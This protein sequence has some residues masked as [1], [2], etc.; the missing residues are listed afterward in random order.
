M[1]SKEEVLSFLDLLDIDEEMIDTRL[2]SIMVRSTFENGHLANALQLLLYK[3][4]VN[5]QEKTECNNTEEFDFVAKLIKLLNEDIADNV[6]KITTTVLGLNS[7]N[8][9][10]F[11][12]HI[13]SQILSD[14]DIFYKDSKSSG[15]EKYKTLLYLKICDSVLDAT[16]KHGKTVSVLFVETPLEEILSSGDEPL[17]VHFITSTVPKLIEGLNGYDMLSR[18]WNHLEQMKGE[19]RNTALKVLSS[20]SDYYLPVS[21]DGKSPKYE[22]E[23]VFKQKFWEV[24]LYG[25]MSDD[26]T[27]RKISVYL[28]KRAIDYVA[29]L[30]INLN[31]KLLDQTLFSWI[32]QKQGLYRKQWDNFFILMDSLEE[33]Q[34]NIV[35]PSLQLF[36]TLTKIDHCWLNCAFNLGLRHDNGQVRLKCIDHRINTYIGSD[37]EAVVLLEAL[38][39]F[40]F[41]DHTL[42]CQIIKEKIAKVLKHETNLIH[43]LRAMPLAHWSPVPFFHISDIIANSK[44]VI[45]SKK[46]ANISNIFIEI[47]K[48]SCNIISIR[49]AIHLNIAHFVGNSCRS[50]DFREI[51]SIYNHLQIKQLTKTNALIALLKDWQLSKE[52]KKELYKYVTNSYSNIQF[53]ILY[54]NNHPEDIDVFMEVIFKKGKIIQDVINRQYANKMECFDDVLY[55]LHFQNKC[56]IEIKQLLPNAN[57]TVIQYIY[58]L[59][60]SNVNLNTEEMKLLFVKISFMRE[61]NVKDSMIQLYKTAVIFLQDNQA[62]L[63]KMVQSL[64]TIDSLTHNHDFVHY[65]SHQMLDLKH[66]LELEASF[67]K[68][69]VS[70]AQS[71]GR[72]RNV[73]Y[74]T[75]CKLVG[76]YLSSIIAT[77]N[78]LQSSHE[79]ESVKNK[80]ETKYVEMSQ[81]DITNIED[82]PS[83][84]TKRQYLNKS[85]ENISQDLVIHVNK[86]DARTTDWKEIIDYVEKI[87]D[88]GGYGC[89]ERI[90]RM[91]NV[92]FKYTI[93]YLNLTKFTS[94]MWKEI[95]ELKSSNYYLPCMKEFINL[96]TQRALISD[97]QFN[98]ITILYYS[99]II[100]YGHINNNPLYYLVHN[101]LLSQFIEKQNSAK[102]MNEYGHLV[103]ILSEILL[104]CPV[105]RKDQR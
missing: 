61:T 12:E 88:C 58:S 20:L 42:D 44:I 69:A 16:I 97:P 10:S 36:D 95:E 81:K 39:D 64:L 45:D 26:P 62:D 41:Y 7:T 93:S 35:L 28:T 1:N 32:H 24:V 75:H 104:Y 91:V 19:S 96:I 47:L 48:T 6:C 50:L 89:L 99:K 55:I 57:K 87:V 30:K 102:K 15:T 92:T 34:S 85:K 86:C 77:D 76:T 70:N 59:L 9:V 5:V 4:L 14:T 90:L 52:D 2:K 53:G 22:S 72:M 71:L 65:F 38:N 67:E 68:K 100:E 103:Y 40:S 31:V 49:D 94:R 33:K 105:P 27:L 98:N 21:I 60:S 18:I 8:L 56:D 54:L 84:E 13:L 46:Y 63:N 11:S 74:E 73:F 79:A 78:I 51:A 17:K 23:L 66:L 29:S 83:E 43:I 37:S 25:L 3:D 82:T 101:D 80:N